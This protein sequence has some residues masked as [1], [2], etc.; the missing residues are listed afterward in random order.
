MNDETVGY[1][2]RSREPAA[3]GDQ[4]KRKLRVMRRQNLAALG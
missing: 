2:V 4:K 3:S 1:S